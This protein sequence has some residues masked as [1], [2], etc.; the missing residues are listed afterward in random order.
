MIHLSLPYQ[1]EMT[2]FMTKNITQ[3]TEKDSLF[4]QNIWHFDKI[5]SFW[6]LGM[7]YIDPIFVQVGPQNGNIRGFY[8]F[9]S[10]LSQQIY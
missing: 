6:K 4:S 7:V 1:Q 2:L 3:S 5:N 9:F 10:E 8:Q